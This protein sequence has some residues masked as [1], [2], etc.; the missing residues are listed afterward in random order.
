M[1]DSNLN[2]KYTVHM[3]EI[4]SLLLKEQVKI[5]LLELKFFDLFNYFFVCFFS[6]LKNLLV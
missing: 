5:V 1:I 4:I 6:L 3:L 2:A